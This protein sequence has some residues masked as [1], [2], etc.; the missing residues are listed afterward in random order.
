M[1][2]ESLLIPPFIWPSDIFAIKGAGL[3]G[4]TAKNLTITP[5][6]H[7]SDR[8]HFGVIGHP[9][10]DDGGYFVDY[11][12]RESL[13]K[14]PTNSR[15]FLYYLGKDVE[16]YRTPGITKEQAMEAVLSTSLIGRASY[17][18]IDFMLMMADAG[19]LMLHG[20]FPPYIAQ[21]LKYSAN[22]AYICTE[23]AAYTRRAINK[24]VEPPGQ[25]NIWDIPTVYLQA[26]EE[27]R[28]EMVYK[29]DLKDLAVA[30]ARWNF[31]GKIHP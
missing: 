2:N 14:G 6:G 7:H 3:L 21:Q 23:E 15:F 31:K 22:D 27:G 1:V 17:G 28:L 10:F 8:V 29:G 25:E 9:V 30:S 19:R 5:S 24:P 26:L 16:I 20:E 13:G 12:T 18:Y 11:E 4:W